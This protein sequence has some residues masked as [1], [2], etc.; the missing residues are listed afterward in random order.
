MKT[1]ILDAIKDAE[2]VCALQTK[3]DPQAF[4]KLYE[5]YMQ[6]VFLFCREKLHDHD[7]AL[8]LTQDI[9]VKASLKINSLKEPRTFA[10]WLFQITRNA[11]YDQL[12]LR[13]RRMQELPESV[14]DFPAAEITDE[15]ENFQHK[16]DQLHVYLTLLD[17]PS[18]MVI[19]AKYLEN[20][21]IKEMALQLH[22]SESAVKMRLSRARQKLESLFSSHPQVLPSSDLLP[23]Q[24]G[25]SGF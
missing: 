14:A 8:D 4:G 3:K 13:K 21:S 23:P 18:R 25:A 1:T 24:P 19:M 10:A 16:L 15:E 9:F 6:A 12:T 5:K 11:C 22:L 7:D 20:K 2:L 17:P